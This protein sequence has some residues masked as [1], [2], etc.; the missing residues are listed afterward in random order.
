MAFHAPIEQ[1]T[2]SNQNYRHVLFTTPQQ[3]LVMMYLPDTTEIGMENHPNTTQ[4]IKIESGEGIAY[5]GKNLYH[6]KSG[7]S[8]VI[9]PGQ[10]H[11]ILANSKEGLKLYTIYSPPEHK[12]GLIEPVKSN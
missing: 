10:N 11:N 7:D 3:Q 12:D 9:P 6:L 2:L 8:I 5:V 4:F 1:L